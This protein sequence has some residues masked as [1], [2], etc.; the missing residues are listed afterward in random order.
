MRNKRN[1]AQPSCALV[2]IEQLYPFP[3]DDYAATIRHY[4]KATEIVWCQ[5]EPQ[6]QG[7]W[8][9]LRHRLQQPLAYGQELF[10]CGRAPAAAPAAGYYQV[11]ITQQEGLVNA[12]LRGDRTATESELIRKKA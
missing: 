12:A 3:V 5:E 2:R 7:A 8:Y 10:Y 6:N 11:H 1:L 9:H 4:P